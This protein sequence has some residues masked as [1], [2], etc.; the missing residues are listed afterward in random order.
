MILLL[1][2]SYATQL[3]YTTLLLS[4]PFFIGQY[5]QQTS[6]FASSISNTYNDALRFYVCKSIIVA[7]QSHRHQ[8]TY[9]HLMLHYNK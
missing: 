9:M 2:L 6:F 4:L 3:T 1:L 7:E 8:H 5:R